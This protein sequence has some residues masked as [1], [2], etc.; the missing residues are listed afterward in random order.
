MGLVLVVPKPGCPA[1][2]T[3]SVRAVSV[4]TILRKP[5]QTDFLYILRI[6]DG[7][8]SHQSLRLGQ[9]RTH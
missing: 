5:E 4:R 7:V 1:F 9:I 6:G 3:L 2:G 8:G